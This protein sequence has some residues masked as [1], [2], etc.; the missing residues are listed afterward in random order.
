VGET[1]GAAGD[2]TAPVSA[3]SNEARQHN[4]IRGRSQRTRAVAQLVATRA[5][6]EAGETLSGVLGLGGLAGDVVGLGQAAAKS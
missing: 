2:A 1:L 6:D 3:V 5:V 4:S